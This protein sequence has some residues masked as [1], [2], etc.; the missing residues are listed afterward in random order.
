MYFIVVHKQHTHTHSTTIHSPHSVRP[1]ELRINSNSQAMKRHNPY[2]TLSSHQD[3][4]PFT[5]PISIRLVCNVTN[6]LLFPF[7]LLSLPPNGL[8]LQMILLH[9]NDRQQKS[10]VIGIHTIQNKNKKKQIFR[11]KSSPPKD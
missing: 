10:K 11:K 8:L 1:M 6:D 2:C 5:L 3:Y 9:I 7:F 4:K